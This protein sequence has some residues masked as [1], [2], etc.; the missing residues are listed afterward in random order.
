M[1]IIETIEVIKKVQKPIKIRVT[2]DPEYFKKYNIR[3]KA[4]I[5]AQKKEYYQKN[6]ERIKEKNKN[7]YKMN[8]EYEN[9]ELKDLI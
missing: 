2:D 9:M 1:E 5:S 3:K 7:R 6:K 4:E 8:K